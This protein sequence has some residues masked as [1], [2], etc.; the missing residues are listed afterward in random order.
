MLKSCEKYI[1]PFLLGS[2]LMYAIKAPFQVL[3]QT[4]GLLSLQGTDNV[5]LVYDPEESRTVWLIFGL[6]T[7]FRRFGE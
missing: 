4:M 7:L 3:E 5:S 6:R 2:T 1:D